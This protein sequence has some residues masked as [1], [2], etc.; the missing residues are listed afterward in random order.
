M[1][2]GGRACQTQ[3]G[4]AGMRALDAGRPGETDVDQGRPIGGHRGHWMQTGGYPSGT[5]RGLHGVSYFDIYFHCHIM[6][7][8]HIKV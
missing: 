6:H 8:I 4:D 3:T 1:S 5:R 7:P 2:I